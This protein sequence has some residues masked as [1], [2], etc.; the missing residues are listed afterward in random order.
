M[1]ETLPT[2]TGDRRISKTIKCSNA[3]AS[4][5][6]GGAVMAGKVQNP[7]WQHSFGD[8]WRKVCCFVMELSFACI[9]A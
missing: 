8:F 3:C 4:P 6:E 5:L 2:S 7:S 9:I 1:G